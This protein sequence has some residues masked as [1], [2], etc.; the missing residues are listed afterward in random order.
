MTLGK[1]HFYFC[2]LSSVDMLGRFTCMKHNPYSRWLKDG[3]YKTL[4]LVSARKHKIWD[5][6]TQPLS[7]HLSIWVMTLC[8]TVDMDLIIRKVRIIFSF[9]VFFCVWFLDISK[10]KIFDYLQCTCLASFFIIFSIT[11]NEMLRK[12][13]F[14]MYW[15]IYI[16]YIW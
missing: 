16:I 4:V 9:Y 5:W 10:I 7:F 12:E 8:M 13:I 6:K 3:N 2:H 11:S 1:S 14:L 15:D